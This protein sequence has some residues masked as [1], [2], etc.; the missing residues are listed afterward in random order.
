MFQMAVANILYSSVQSDPEPGDLVEPVSIV[1][2]QISVIGLEWIFAV[3][4]AEKGAYRE[5]NCSDVEERAPVFFKNV[6]AYVSRC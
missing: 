2:K 3:G 6:K 4:V 1:L 5:E